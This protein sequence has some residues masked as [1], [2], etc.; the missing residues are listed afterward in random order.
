MGISYAKIDPETVVGIWLLNEGEG[1]VAKDSSENGFDGTIEGAEWVDG[2]FGSALSFSKA[3]LDTVYVPI[4][5][6]MITDKITIIMLVNFQDL[7]GQQNYF[8]LE[9]DSSNRYIFM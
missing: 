7:D 4:A 1:D 2:R 8:C 6:E 3:A 9:G 5:S